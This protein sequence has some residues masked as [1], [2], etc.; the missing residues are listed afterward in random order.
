MINFYFLA[1][2]VI[3][4]EVSQLILNPKIIF[5]LLAPGLLHLMLCFDKPNHI[6]YP[7][8]FTRLLLSSFPCLGGVSSLTLQ[9]REAP[10]KRNMFCTQI[11]IHRELLV[12]STDWQPQSWIF[13]AE[14]VVLI[15]RN[16][17]ESKGRTQGF[18][19]LSLQ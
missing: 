14:G 13:H 16:K 8:S 3:R 1:I 9:E 6:Q 2:P 4:I 7:I 11:P 19:C 5:S 15:S 12:G 18:Y 17:I 10:G